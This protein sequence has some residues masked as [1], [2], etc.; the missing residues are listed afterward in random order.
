VKPNKGLKSIKAYIQLARPHQYVKNGFIWLPV[1][2]GNKLWE[3]AAV[4]DTFWAFLIFSLAASSVYALN[5]IRDAGEDRMHPVKSS[6]PVASGALSPSQ[7]MTF[8]VVTIV[9]TWV[10][11][12]LLMPSHF[13]LVLLAYL[14][15]NLSYSLYLKHMALVDVVCISTGFVLR[16]LAGGISG[17]VAVSHWIITMTF[18]LALFMAFA[19]RRDD[20]LLAVAGNRTRRCLDGYNLEFISL[21]MGIMAAVII[22]SYVLYSIS[23][24]V[25]GKHGT[26][27]LYL[28]GFWVILG[29]LRYMQVTFVEERSG[30]PTQVLLKDNFLRTVALLWILTCYLLLY[31]LNR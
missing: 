2:F 10:L 17:D 22:V 24:E 21:S 29:I 3:P 4:L 28:S 5:D 19:K 18:L 25:T 1:F 26:D 20:L 7:A 6:R 15:L 12:L 9:I 27:Q 23:P 8:L 14:L 30:S 16:V 11:T 31:G 13:M